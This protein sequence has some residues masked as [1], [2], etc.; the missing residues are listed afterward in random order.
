MVRTLMLALEAR[1]QGEVPVMHPIMLW[2][3]EHAG[4]LITKYLVGHDGKT[5]YARLFGTPDR[6]EGYEF[7]ERVMCKRSAGSS[8]SARWEDGIWLGRRWGSITH[9]VATGPGEV[10]EV[11]AVVR[12]PLSERWPREELQALRATVG[13]DRPE[14]GGRGGSRSHPSCAGGRWGN[15]G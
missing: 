2:L 3:V 8:L 9:I 14:R 4:E 10:C 6:G 1:I 5:A 11:R 13:V 7:G 12:K 15:P